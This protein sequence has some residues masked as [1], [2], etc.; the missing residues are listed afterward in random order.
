M[1]EISFKYLNITFQKEEY[2]NTF[3]VFK[4]SGSPFFSRFSKVIEITISNKTLIIE[5]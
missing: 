1:K 5:F 2:P 4:H 3:R